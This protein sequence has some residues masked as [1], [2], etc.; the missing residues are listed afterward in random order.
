MKKNRLFLFIYYAVLLFI[1][2]SWRD[3]EE[4]PNLIYRCAF[5]VAAVIPAAN[6][7]KSFLA[8]VVICFLAIC[9]NGFAHGYMPDNLLFYIALLIPCLMFFK[10]AKPYFILPRYL[11]IFFF[12][13]SLIDLITGLSVE[14]ITL[15]FLVSALL[16]TFTTAKSRDDIELWSLCF[17]ICSLSLSSMFLLNREQF[18]QAYYYQ[19]LER[20]TW[21]DPN[22]FG[23]VVGIGYV[24]ALLRLLGHG[25]SIGEKINIWY[26][27]LFIVTIVLSLV[28]LIL[29]ASRGAL[30]AAGVAT[31]IAIA[32][33]KLKMNGKIIVVSILIIGLIYLYQNSYF[34]LLQYR[35]ENENT[36]GGNGRSYIWNIKLRAFFNGNPLSM[37]FGYGYDGGLTLG[38]NG[39][40]RGTHNDYLAILFD[41]GFIGLCM[42]VVMLVK[43]VIEA[44]K[45]SNVRISVYVLLAYLAVCCFTLEPITG[46]YIPYLFFYCYIVLIAYSG[47]KKNKHEANIIYNR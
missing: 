18:A 5:L 30:L 14:K 20:T 33:S 34:D 11:W 19:G 21:M 46:A 1:M 15:T 40:K 31:I 45:V 12:Y 3:T 39:V 23:M 8:P 43:P 29:N 28:V 38:Y 22:Y 25:K 13:F 35:F 6:Y 37:L 10:P 7:D 42:F 16:M 44:L 41:Y 27:I 4:A 32:F 9:Q 26:K 47:N 36:E 2:L 17:I 24:V